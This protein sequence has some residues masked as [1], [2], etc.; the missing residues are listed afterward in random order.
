MLQ[1]FFSKHYAVMIQ[2]RHCTRNASEQFK[3]KTI[4]PNMIGEAGK[5]F[6]AA[7]YNDFFELDETPKLCQN[8]LLL[9]KNVAR[10]YLPIC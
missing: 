4:D 8:A 9:T 2:L 7:V 5:Q 3:Q 6:L 1:I 10:L